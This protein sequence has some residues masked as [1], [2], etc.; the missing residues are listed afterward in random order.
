LNKLL[1]LGG[2]GLLL[3]TLSRAPREDA[4]PNTAEGYS[5][6][7][8]SDRALDTP[9]ARA[10]LDNIG[11]VYGKN[12][13]SDVARIIATSSSAAEAI[14]RIAR[15]VSSP[16]A[17]GWIN[18]YMSEDPAPSA[19]PSTTGPSAI[20]RNPYGLPARSDYQTQLAVGPYGQASYM[21]DTRAGYAAAFQ[22]YGLT[23]DQGGW[24]NQRQAASVFF[25]LPSDLRRF[26]LS[27]YQ[28]TVVDNN[29]TGP[30][31]A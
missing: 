18:P 27:E 1:L 6:K 31:G 24:I 5:Q 3:L 29:Y 22:Q 13:A 14:Q 11:S 20:L 17:P 30:V 9:I 28:I 4:V 21:S 12:Y 26:L 23:T 10:A 8:E 7:R 25:P 16:Y 15:N 19:A 2:A